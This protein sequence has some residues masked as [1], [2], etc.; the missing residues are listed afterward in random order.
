MNTWIYLKHVVNYTSWKGTGEFSPR[1]NKCTMVCWG[2]FTDTICV[3]VLQGERT[4]LSIVFFKHKEGTTCSLPDIPWPHSYNHN[5]AVGNK[6]GNWRGSVDPLS[7]L[8]Y[9]ISFSLHDSGNVFC[10]DIIFVTYRRLQ[11]IWPKFL[12]C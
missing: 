1:Q 9:S 3:E 6:E 10:K 4:W 2:P 12:K 8:L 7:V 11:C 5:G